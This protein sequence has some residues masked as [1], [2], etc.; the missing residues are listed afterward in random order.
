MKNMQNKLLIAIFSFLLGSLLS[1]MYT[2]C[3]NKLNNANYE[4][5][6]ILKNGLLDS[7]EKDKK[8]SNNLNLEVKNKSELKTQVDNHS[9]IGETLTCDITRMNKIKLSSTEFLIA[10]Y[11][12]LYKIDKN[13]KVKWKYEIGSDLIDFTYIKHNGLVYGTAHDNTMFIL[14]VNT[15]EELERISRNGSL[16]FGQLVQYKGLCL[17]VDNNW[18][19]RDRLLDNSIEDGLTAWIGT[20]DIWHIDIP[21]ES[22]IVIKDDKI[23]ALTINNGRI[24]F[25]KLKQP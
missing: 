6:R 11:D 1:F 2:Q 22:T 17:I 13:K 8:I 14:N 23:F 25:K 21:P 12:T 9:D 19:Y 7:V 15:G 18:G 4:Q 24:S 3:I 16:A 20:K 5:K 10:V